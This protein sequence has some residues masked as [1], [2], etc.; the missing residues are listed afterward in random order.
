MRV[1]ARETRVPF[2]MSASYRRLVG[3]TRSANAASLVGGKYRTLLKLGTGGAANVVVAVSQDVGGL[4]KL[5]ALK[6]LRDGTARSDSVVK[7]HMDEAR[8]SARMSHPNVVQVFELVQHDGLPVIV[9]EYVEGQSL[10]TILGAALRT[11][12]FTLDVRLT[13]LTKALAGLHY[14]H[15]LCNFS[16]EPLNLVHCDFSPQNVMVGYGGQVKLADF[17][18]ARVGTSARDA[19]AGVQGKLR[20]MAPELI[21]GEVDRRADVFAAGVVLWELVVGRRFWGGLDEA[22]TMARL[23]T[24]EIPT[25]HAAKPQV[26][27]ELQAICDKALAHDPAE[28]QQTAAELAADLEDYLVRRG[29]LVSDSRIGDVVA[30]ACHEL[31]ARSQ[32]AIQSQLSE[33]DELQGEEAPEAC[34]SRN[35]RRW[36][37]L[38]TALGARWRPF[39]L[40]GLGIGLGLWGSLSLHQAEHDGAPGVPLPAPG[41]QTNLAAPAAVEGTVDAGEAS[42]AALVREPQVKVSISV[43]P[44]FAEVFWDDERLPSNAYAMLVPIDGASHTLRAA[45]EGFEPFSSLFTPD[46]DTVITVALQE[47]TAVAPQPPP[48]ARRAVLQGST[49]SKARARPRPEE[50]GNGPIA[51]ERLAE[52]APS[53]PAELEPGSDLRKLR[54]FRSMDGTELQ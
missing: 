25:L 52:H 30:R 18:I 42:V 14:A 43:T 51:G 21:T 4:G 3:G 23:V 31:R 29:A 7:A 1:E 22:T 15:S 24:G 36:R 5:V 41:P 32:S 45:A 13:I 39:W 26:G 46:A 2:S 19:Q 38:R 54:R 50:R 11:P 40:G 53:G 48:P 20:Y 47:A 28:R 8:L 17:G 10:A 44:E 16:G 49:R 35:S 6:T 37:V 34:Y 27:R 12:E 9:M 33:L